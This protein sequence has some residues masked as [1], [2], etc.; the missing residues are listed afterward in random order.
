MLF[1]EFKMCEM[2]FIQQIQ[3]VR[4]HIVWKE[5]QWHKEPILNVAESAAEF[6]DGL[7]RWDSFVQL[8]RLKKRADIISIGNNFVNVKCCAE[9][10]VAQRGYDE[11]T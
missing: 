9:H 3:S 11:Q 7:I 2:S 1:L 10:E 8:S 4:P 5:K 6:N